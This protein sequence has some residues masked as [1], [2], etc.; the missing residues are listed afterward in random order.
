MSATLFFWFFFCF[1]L[2]IL[3]LFSSAT[4]CG[5]CPGAARCHLA[6]QKNPLAMIYLNNTL[7]THV[8]GKH[9]NRK[10]GRDGLL[11]TVSDKFSNRQPTKSAASVHS[12]EG[13]QSTASQRYQNAGVSVID[14]ATSTISLSFVWELKKASF[15]TFTNVVRI[16]HLI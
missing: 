16:Y 7:R 6:S 13:S 2:F 4:T 1:S 15:Q 10:G 11:T 14:Y 8:L 5:E 12:A 3:H 9:A